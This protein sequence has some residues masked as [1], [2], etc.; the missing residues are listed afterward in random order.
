MHLNTKNI[1][2]TGG[3]GTGKTSII[4]QLKKQNYYCFD[5]IIRALTLEAKNEVETSSQISNP[6]AFVNDPMDFNSKLLNGRIEQFIQANKTNKKLNFFDRGIPDVLAYMDFFNQEYNDIFTNACKIHKYNNVFLLPPWKAIYKT[7]NER[8]E[9]FDEAI[10]IHECLKQI[11]KNFEYNIIEVP[12]GT[13]E[14][15]TNYIINSI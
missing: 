15:R 3:P 10:K 13:V 12:F 5:E 9:T 2:I 14:E 8:F 11:Y 4:N 7:D 6:I 1:V